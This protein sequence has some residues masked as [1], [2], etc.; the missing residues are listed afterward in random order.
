MASHY[1]GD[2]YEKVSNE[3]PSYDNDSQGAIDELLN[4]CKIM[5]KIVST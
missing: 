1:S 4:E 3:F 5:Y 2:E